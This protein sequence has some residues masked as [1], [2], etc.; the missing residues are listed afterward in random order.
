MSIDNAV[1][2]AP[3]ALPIITADQ[4]LAEPRIPAAQSKKAGRPTHR[5]VFGGEAR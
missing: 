5:L 1:G 4:R 3:G 2:G